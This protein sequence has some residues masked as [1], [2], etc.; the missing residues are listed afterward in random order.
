MRGIPGERVRP[1]G[2]PSQRSA[3]YAAESARRSA[4][5]V[6]THR[7][8]P[9]VRPAEPGGSSPSA[10]PPLSSVPG[11]SRPAEPGGSRRER[12]RRPVEVAAGEGLAPVVQGVLGVVQR[13][14]VGG[15]ASLLGEGELPRAG[16]GSA[17]GPDLVLSVALSD[18]RSVPGSPAAAWT[19]AGVVQARRTTPPAPPRPPERALAVPAGY[20]VPHSTEAF[21]RYHARTIPGRITAA[22]TVAR[23]VPR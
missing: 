18:C 15:L 3:T 16:F 5:T 10:R 19:G 22:R 7:H 8:T 9:R 14:V 12:R 23:R 2:M 21:A 4:G 20:R 13:V 1:P 6:I 11:G 17:A